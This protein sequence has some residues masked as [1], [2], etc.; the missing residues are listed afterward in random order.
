MIYDWL[1][2]CISN[3]AN[4]SDVGAY[5]PTRVIDVGS[6]DELSTS[7]V[8]LVQPRELQGRTAAYT[9][10]SRCWGPVS[11]LVKT[12]REN[13]P[14]HLRGLAFNLLPKTYRDAITVTRK[15]KIQYLWIDSLCIVQDDTVDW[16]REAAN[17]ALVYSHAHLTIAAAS[18]ADSTG[19]CYIDDAIQPTDLQIKIVHPKGM[20]TNAYIRSPAYRPNT[21][22]ESP[23]HQRGCIFQEVFCLEGHC[24]APKTRCFGNAILGSKLKTD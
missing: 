22:Y 7:C 5:L 3:H 4:C 2:E 8:R 1:A 17:M 12:T 18:A 19:G 13:L 10:L 23:L 15:L 16:Q 9:A 21:F 6:A 20:Q 11:N 14:I 24:T